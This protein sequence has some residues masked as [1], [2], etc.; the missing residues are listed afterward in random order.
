MDPGRN[1]VTPRPSRKNI[2]IDFCLRLMK[3]PFHGSV[4][5]E[6]VENS[7]KRNIYIYIYKKERERMKII[8]R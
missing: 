4:S 3:N 8:G 7:K 5:L 1:I 6:M 2:N